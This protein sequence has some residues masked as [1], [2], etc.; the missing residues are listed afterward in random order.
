MRKVLGTKV[1][2]MKE[3]RIHQ[4]DTPQNLYYHPKD[5]FVAEFIGTPQMNFINVDV[6]KTNKGIHMNFGEYS[7]KTPKNI[8]L[9]LEKEGYI[10]KDL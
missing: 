2:V 9:E 10:G 1:A 7:I 3:G 4:I 8:E 5:I 6:A